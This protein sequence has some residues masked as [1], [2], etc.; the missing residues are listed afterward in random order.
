[1]MAWVRAEDLHFEERIG[2]GEFGEVWKGTYKGLEVAIKKLYHTES[3]LIQRYIK[4]EVESLVLLLHPAIVKLFGLC[5]QE[6]NVFIITEFVEGGNLKEVLKRTRP[7]S[8]SLH[9][10]QS[11][12]RKQTMKEEL[13]E[14]EREEDSKEERRLGIIS[15][16]LLSQSWRLKLRW[17]HDV[18]M[19]M[20]YLHQQ[21]VIHRD[22]KS[23][24]LLVGNNLEVKICD[25]GLAR[26]GITD[27]EKRLTGVGTNRWMAPEVA[28]DEDYGKPADVFSFGLIL[29]ELCIHRQPP[30]R[31]VL[32]MFDFNKNKA[33]ELIP[34]DTPEQLWQLICDCTLTNSNKRPK[35]SQVAERLRQIKLRHPNGKA[36]EAKDDKGEQEETWYTEAELQRWLGEESKKNEK[37]EIEPSR[38]EEQQQTERET[39]EER[40]QRLMKER[41]KKLL[42]LHVKDSFESPIDF[43][44]LDN[45]NAN[46]KPEKQNNNKNESRTKPEMQNEQTA[47]KKE[48]QEEETT[49]NTS[50][51]H[52]KTNA[53]LHKLR[54]SIR[55][56]RSYT[57]ESSTEM[58]EAIN[59]E[60]AESILRRSSPIAIH[61]HRPSKHKG[62]T[63]GL[64]RSSSSLDRTSSS[65]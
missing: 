28:L 18:A 40:R 57:K 17:A 7:V 9:S 64:I 46:N 42:V 13:T 6:G 47:P 34:A 8:P 15:S 26:A 30:K 61:N 10:P 1:M 22:L 11:Q 4:R 21:G 39:A 44:G 56:K 59:K 33:K 65:S 58:R 5:K 50:K 41:K 14:E 48:Q 36:S 62:K 27:K 52:D 23:P 2:K 16:Q 45:T 55:R 51:K 19:A 49:N 54:D 31:S 60:E 43:F 53:T 35:F 32:E 63:L 25:L 20:T 3:H 24:N 12:T 29:L 37:A 38:V